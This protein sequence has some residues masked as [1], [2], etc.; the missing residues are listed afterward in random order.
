[1]TREYEFSLDANGV[2]G[3]ARA[4]GAGAGNLKKGALR[5]QVDIL[6]ADLQRYGA[7]TTWDDKTRAANRVTKKKD[8]ELKIT[9]HLPEFPT[10][11]SW[12]GC[13]LRCVLAARLVGT[14]LYDA[15]AAEILRY[16]DATIKSPQLS[17]VND[18]T[19]SVG[20]V[21]ADAEL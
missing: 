9:L 11:Y 6:C 14:P 21:D 1:M 15:V 5:R 13:E 17:S 2:L 7:T 10:G 16:I 3:A 19:L 8:R 4:C 12:F 18:N 20:E